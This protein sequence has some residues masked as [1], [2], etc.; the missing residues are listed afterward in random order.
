MGN[1]NIPNLTKG[2]LARARKMLFDV[3][4]VL[5]NA[6]IV[7][8][9]EG[10]TLLGIVRDGDLL[11]WDHD[12]D[13]SIM[14]TDTPKFLKIKKELYRKGYKVTSRKSKHDI[15]P[16]KM[17]DYKIFKIKKIVPSIVK[18]L[19][20]RYK[21]NY[22]VLDIFIKVNDGNYCYWQAMNKLMRV[23]NKYYASYETVNYRGASLKVPNDYK[24]YLTQKYGDWSVPVKEW[25][26][27]EDEKTI[28]S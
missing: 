4:E 18:L 1:K 23:S 16:F 7:Y 11:P 24:D 26:C 20:P 17:G 21:K 9:L 8:H 25:V 12:V 15:H 27:G 22:I 10:G 3:V 19:F 2:N 13:L 5:D 6:N 28:V 14:I